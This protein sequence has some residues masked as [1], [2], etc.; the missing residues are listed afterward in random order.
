MWDERFNQAEYV[1]GKEPNEFLVAMAGQIPLGKVLCLAEGEGRN[2]CFLASL[3]YD[4]TALD[5][6]AVGLAKA[7]KLAAEKGVKITT[8]QSDLQDFAITPDT[9][10]GIISIFCHLPSNL[11]AQLYSK[12]YQGLRS[13]GVFILEGF[14]PEQL[15]YNS[16]GPKDLDLL[17]SLMTLKQELSSFSHLTTKTLERELNEGAY[18]QGPAALIQILGKK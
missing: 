14:A 1:Y 7:Q 6:S 18:H 12:V 10:Q 3:G 17:P 5:Q 13:G 2:A 9:W 11:R 15:Q 8:V 16:G 4:V